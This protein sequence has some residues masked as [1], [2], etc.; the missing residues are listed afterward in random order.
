VAAPSPGPV[1]DRQARVSDVSYAAALGAGVVSFL[2]RCVLPLVPVY[3]SLVSSFEVG[4]RGGQL[5]IVR[6]TAGAAQRGKR[7][8]IVEPL[9]VVTGGDE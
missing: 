9:R 8:V 5:G 1:P 6:D 4:R 3:L 2:S 7:C